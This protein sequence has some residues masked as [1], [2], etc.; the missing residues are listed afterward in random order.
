MQTQMEGKVMKLKSYAVAALLALSAAVLPCGA[1]R[2]DTVMY[3]SSDFVQGAQSYL[4]SLDITTPGTLTL[5]LSGVPWLDIVNDTSGFLTSASGLI[6]S[7]SPSD[8]QSFSGSE[9]WNVST[10]TFY[11]HWFGKADGTNDLGVLCA[12]IVFT[13]GAST[14]ALPATWL[15]LLSGLVVLA[16]L[17]RRPATSLVTA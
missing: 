17:K 14:V 8:I 2:A 7:T 5:T 3:D 11:A 9:T 15:L 1:A 10:G 4:Q 12:K 6:P 13:P 16:R